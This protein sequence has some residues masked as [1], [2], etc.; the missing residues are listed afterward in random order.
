MLLHVM[1]DGARASMIALW[2]CVVALTFPG[3]ATAQRGASSDG[4]LHGPAVV[5]YGGSFEVQVASAGAAVA[6]SLGGPAVSLHPVGPN[7]R[8]IIP[9]PAE[10]GPGTI[11]LLIVGRG[12]RASCLPVEVVD[13]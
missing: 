3:P 6:I 2:T 11:M 5:P 1:R 7:H 9:V 12:L 8:V 10:A 13:P 4:N